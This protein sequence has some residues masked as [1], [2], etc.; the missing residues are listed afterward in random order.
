MWLMILVCLA[1]VLGALI[2]RKEGAVFVSPDETA[3]HFFA[4]TYA[5]TGRLFAEER[6]NVFLNDALHPRSVLSL[7][8]RLVP[9]SFFGLPMIAGT[10]AVLFGD[11]SVPFTPIVLS[12]LAVLA[13]A[14]VCRRVFSPRIGWLS[15]I[16]LALHP[17]WL[18][19][20]AR[21]LM[22][23]VILVAL[24]IFAAFF[25]VVRPCASFMYSSGK[26]RS[27][28]LARTR[29]LAAFGK[30]KMR[31]A[32]GICAGACIGLAMFARASEAVWIMPAMML[33]LVWKRK[34][35]GWQTIMGA[36]AALCVTLIPLFVF[37]KTLYGSWTLTGYTVPSPTLSSFLSQ[38][39][40]SLTE[41]SWHVGVEQALSPILP[42][43]VH[44]FLAWRQFFSYGLGMFWWA[45]LAA[46][47]GIAIGGLRLLKRER[48]YRFV[49][50]G[51]LRRM[52]SRNDE[53]EGHGDVGDAGTRCAWTGYFVLFLGISF[54][55]ILLYGSWTFSDNPDPTQLTI[56]NSHV[57]YWLP[58]FVL[59]TP[60]AAY[61]IDA[62]ARWCVSW[63][64]DR[65]AGRAVYI[66]LIFLY[67]F[68][69]F[70]VAFLD[71]QDGLFAAAR[72]LAESHVIRDGV[73]AITEPDAVIV[74]DRGDKL[75]FPHRR[76]LYPLRDEKTYALMPRIVE[77][78]P[79]YYFGITLPAQDLDYLNA[80][81]LKALG[82]QIK[83][84]QTFWMETL[85]RIERN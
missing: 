32:D 30:W 11:G 27:M 35:V 79:L 53:G 24:L 70:R 75:F 33:L 56:G 36:C 49:E 13:W 18:Y 51:L 12:V 26:Q 10:V 67:A 64:V 42:F 2:L 40:T 85:Y 19:Y 9:A 82:L 65:L 54:W 61:A 7:N 17:A 20:T 47:L 14:A 6:L 62:C 76:V 16:M 41:P 81:K 83:P 25:L 3:A 34:T 31:W 72:I 71:P 80:E 78:A 15:G 77:R 73:L 46:I 22:P 37:Q 4:T 44:P 8:G 39:E 68:L 23:N 50:T 29:F 84:V 63:N 58:I 5:H 66:L 52:P 28:G 60:F 69:G 57:R 59:A 21:S 55:L 38:A 48:L 74:V 43:G 1:F 45:F